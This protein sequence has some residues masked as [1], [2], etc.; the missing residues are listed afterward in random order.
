LAVKQWKEVVW[1]M[2]DDGMNL[3]K[4]DGH[5]VSVAVLTENKY[6]W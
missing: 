5:I 3:V 1:E 6:R 4:V 2:D